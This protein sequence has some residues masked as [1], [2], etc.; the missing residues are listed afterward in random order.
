M[1][2]TT[3]EFPDLV[4]YYTEPQNEYKSYNN[5]SNLALLNF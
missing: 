3:R 2:F 1:A 5:I 4:K